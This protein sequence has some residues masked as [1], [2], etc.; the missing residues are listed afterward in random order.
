MVEYKCD[1]CHAEFPS[2]RSLASHR[3]HCFSIAKRFVH[4]DDPDVSQLFNKPLLASHRE[5]QPRKGLVGGEECFDYHGLFQVGGD[6]GDGDDDAGDD[7]DE[8]TDEEGKREGHEEEQEDEDD[9]N[10]SDGEAEAML[11]RPIEEL[12]RLYK[13]ADLPQVDDPQMKYYI[14]QVAFGDE[15]FGNKAMQTKTWSDFKYEVKD[16]I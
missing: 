13:K 4:L 1:V 12:A 8:D 9:E 3:G 7:D 11:N 10:A 2:K 14:E 6:G 5:S 15:M 16:F